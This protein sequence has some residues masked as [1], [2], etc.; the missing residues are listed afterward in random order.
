[1]KRSKT[2]S[3]VVFSLGLGSCVQLRPIERKEPV[4]ITMGQRKIVRIDDHTS[5]L[6]LMIPCQGSSK[7]PVRQRIEVS[8]TLEPAATARLKGELQ[9]LPVTFPV[10][11]VEKRVWE[12][13]IS[14]NQLQVLCKESMTAEYEG[15]LKLNASGDSLPIILVFNDPSRHEPIPLPPKRKSAG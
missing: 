10:R 7:E 4:A 6:R 2:L 8:E 5:A 13:E 14:P 3:M 9:G 11:P 12:L 1:M 15:R